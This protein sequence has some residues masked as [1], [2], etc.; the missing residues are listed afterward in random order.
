MRHTE[1]KRHK[2]EEIIYDKENVSDFQN[3]DGCA[4]DWCVPDFIVRWTCHDI[5]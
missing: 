4:Y 3:I 5:G 2:Y 1:Y